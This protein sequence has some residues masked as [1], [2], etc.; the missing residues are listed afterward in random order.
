MSEILRI[1]DRTMPY[2]LACN[3]KLFE[4]NEVHCTR[5]PNYFVLILMINGVLQFAEE[6][7]EITLHPGQWYIQRRGIFHTGTHPCPDAEY[8]YIHF[9][10]TTTT[11]V[12]FQENAIEI[13]IF[14]NFSY[15]IYKNNIETIWKYFTSGPWKQLQLQSAFL[16]L[17]GQLYGDNTHIAPH[18]RQILDYIKANYRQRMTGAMLAKEFNFSEKYIE[19][20]VKAQFHMTPHQYLTHLRLENA[21][22]Q[23]D[24]TNISLKEIS[25]NSGFTDPSLFYR[26]FVKS[27]G[28]SPRAW[29]K[30]LMGE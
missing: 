16:Q 14:G 5:K 11:G 1:A 2:L 10:C 21:K 28:I 29:R 27:N 7:T 26:A 19:R 3:Y 23:L 6:D 12:A 4:K 20:I 18:V 13:P 24:Q 22:Q 9:Q 25:E 30:K 8:F 15:P 17:L